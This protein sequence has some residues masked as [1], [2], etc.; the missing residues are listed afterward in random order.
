MP[1][2]DLDR[3]VAAQGQTYDRALNE[4]RAGAKRS[5]WMWYVFPQ[6]AGLG[7]SSMAQRYGIA[8]LAEAQAYLAH[9]VLGGRLREITM[10][11]ADLPTPDA[12]AVF[13]CID[14]MKLRSSLTLFSR[15]DTQA[16]SLFRVALDRWFDG[17]EDPATVERL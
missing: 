3:F 13:G 16:D 12:V 14:T 5:H 8:D 7:Q 1:A 4:I 17:S 6:I 10:A 9:P 2:H 15:A 11:L